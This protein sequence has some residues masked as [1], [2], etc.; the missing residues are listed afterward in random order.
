MYSFKLLKVLNK[1]LSYEYPCLFLFT[2]TPLFFVYIDL[3][4][5]DKLNSSTSYLKFKLYIILYTSC[6][7]VTYDSR[8]ILKEFIKA[9]HKF[10]PFSSVRS[11]L[12]YTGNLSLK[13]YGTTLLLL[14]GTRSGKSAKYCR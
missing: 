5:V 8:S 2:Y 9:R 1:H 14:G 10:A 7:I 6:I 13:R 12:L 3:Q 4:I 11:S